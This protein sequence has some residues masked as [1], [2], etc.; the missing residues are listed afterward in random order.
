MDEKPLVYPPVVLAHI[1][2]NLADYFAPKIRDKDSVEIHYSAQL[3]GHPHMG[4]LTSLATAFTVG[5]Y[6]AEIF[7]KEPVIKFEALD[8]APVGKFS[9][10]G[11][12]Y[13]RMHAH[14]LVDGIPLSEIHMASFLRVMNYFS[15]STD[16]KFEVETYRDFQKNPFVRSKLLEIIE[17]EE[18][19]VPFIA[20]SEGKLRIRFPCESCDVMEKTSKDSIILDGSNPRDLL[21]QSNCP[22]HGDYQVRVSADSDTL[23]DFN[24]SLR[25]V[26]KEAKFIEDARRSNAMSLMVDGG[27]WTGMAFQVM[28]SLGLMGYSISDLPLRVFSPIIEDWSSAKFSKSVYVKEGTYKHIP[29]EFLN[30]IKFRKTF[31][32]RGLDII[33]EEAQRWVEDP[34]KLFRNYS[35][36]YLRKVFNI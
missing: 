29:E 36:D 13:C 9:I 27:D 18:E 23:I 20:P 28:Q 7:G 31:G 35:T 17:R 21:Y 14:H 25:N 33:L 10:D 2:D 5:K 3:N 19:F 12:E 22:E 34:K 32:D 26:I 11:R 8:N 16:V 15:S 4:T 6:I 30:Y 24:T 1:V